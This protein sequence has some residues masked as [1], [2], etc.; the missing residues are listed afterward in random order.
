[1]L[2]GKNMSSNII[3]ITKDEG[4]FEAQ[5]KMAINRIRHLPVIDDK[6]N[7]IG[8]ITDRDIRNAMPSS[9]VSD[10]VS[11]EEI[12]KYN[13]EHIMTK[14][15]VTV[16]IDDTI[17]DA[18]LLI[19]KSRVGAFPVVDRES[20][21]C[22]IVSVRDL[23]RAFISVLGINTPGTLICVVVEE[24]VGMMKKVVDA[25][26]EENISVGSILVSRHWDKNKK[27][28][29]PYLLTLN[30]SRLKKRLADLGFEVLNPMQWYI[31]AN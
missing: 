1:M 29:F 26:Y 27:A 11:I 25:I 10:P 28:V 18:L 14:N 15:P 22:G 9:L 13:V 17:Q 19:Q 4:I 5:D 16:S 12:K 20:R 3:T 21:L 8:I 7:L 24:K 31:D 23:L 6:Y 2:I 30:V